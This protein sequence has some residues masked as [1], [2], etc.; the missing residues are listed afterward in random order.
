MV[1]KNC[2]KIMGEIRIKF[3]RFDRI[4]GIIFV[5]LKN[6]FLPWMMRPIPFNYINLKGGVYTRVCCTISVLMKT[7]MLTFVELIP[8]AWSFC[9]ITC[10]VHWYIFIDVLFHILQWWRSTSTVFSLTFNAIAYHREEN[11]FIRPRWR[12]LK[13]SN[14]IRCSWKILFRTSH[15]RRTK[16]Y[17]HLSRKRLFFSDCKNDTYQLFYKVN[18]IYIWTPTVSYRLEGNFKCHFSEN[19]KH[20]IFPMN[21]QNANDYLSPVIHLEC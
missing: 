18:V 14:V 16:T 3:K 20:L 4:F 2:Q 12:K 10:Y 19:F 21:E 9:Y 17:N 5:D 7:D 15:I 13:K 11:K 1:S 8:L 6:D